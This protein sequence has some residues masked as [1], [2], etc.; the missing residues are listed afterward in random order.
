MTWLKLPLLWLF[1]M[2]LLAPVFGLGS[3]PALASDA[4][5]TTTVL[6]LDQ[7]ARVAADTPRFPAA[8]STQTVQLP[9]EWRRREL[10]SGPGPVSVWYRLVFD[11]PS[12]MLPQGSGAAE[13]DPVNGLLAER[14]CGQLTVYLNGHKLH[15]DAQRLSPGGN[16]CYG[17]RLVA[18]PAA[19]MRERGNELDLR[20]V[21]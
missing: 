11:A 8:A 21:A 15:A 1:A 7:A 2:G 12:A 5:A 9:D 13:L 17:S 19:L 6:R 20:L 4:A 10:N 14:A 3:R 18:L 16:L